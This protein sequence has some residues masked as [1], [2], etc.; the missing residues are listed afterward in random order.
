MTM[1]CSSHRSGL[2]HGAEASLIPDEA[3]ALYVNLTAFRPEITSGI[4]ARKGI[5]YAIFRTFAKAALGLES[6]VVTQPFPRP[7]DCYEQCSDGDEYNQRDGRDGGAG[8]EPA[9]RP[10]R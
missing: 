7:E 4:R 1:P 2:Q 10:G 5:R 9:L 3:C 6:G 8:R